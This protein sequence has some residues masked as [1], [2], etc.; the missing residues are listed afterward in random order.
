MAESGYE[1]WA[2]E[3]AERRRAGHLVGT[4]AAV[5]LE[6]SGLGPYE[7]AEVRVGP[8]GAI[9]VTVGGASLGQGI[10]TVLAQIA[11]DALG[12]CPQRP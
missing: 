2:R 7:V 8:S 10:E 5:F 11:A 6:K 4:G 1:S 3:A 12:A 9:Q